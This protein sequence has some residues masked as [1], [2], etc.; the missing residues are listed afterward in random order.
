[1]PVCLLMWCRDDVR[2]LLMTLHISVLG[3]LLHDEVNTSIYMTFFWCLILCTFAGALDLK[4]ILR[5]SLEHEPSV[6]HHLFSVV[7]HRLCPVSPQTAS[8]LFP[9]IDPLSPRLFDSWPSTDPGP[10]WHLITLASDSPL[11]WQV[12]RSRCLSLSHLDFS[13]PALQSWRG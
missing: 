6:V 5:V 3:W 1:M 8:V 11:A 13:G 4:T 10:V 9:F 12:A 7:K 2:L